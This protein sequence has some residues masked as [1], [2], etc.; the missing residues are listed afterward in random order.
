MTLP[1]TSVRSPFPI[2]L[3]AVAAAFAGL[4]STPAA[5][6]SNSAL[7]RM[8]ERAVGRA[9]TST[10]NRANQEVDSAVDKGVD[11]MFNPIECAK[12]TQTAPAGTTPPGEPGATGVPNAADTSEWYAESQGQR[13]GPMP[14]DQ[15]AS[16][17][18]SGQVT[19]QSLVWREGFAAWTPAGQVAELGDAFK[20]VPPPLP[21]KSGPPPLPQR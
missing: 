19:A 16:M 15:L 21:Q 17:V 13:V 9:Q 3:A 7:D 20:K 5:A 18:A 14:R 10:E 4:L 12:K 2:A 8:R 6:Q 1:P 11:C